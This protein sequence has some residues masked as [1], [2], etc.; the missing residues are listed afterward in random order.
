[1]CMRNK[2]SS[3]VVSTTEPSGD[4]DIQPVSFC[5]ITYHIADLQ[6]LFLSGEERDAASMEAYRETL[7]KLYSGGAY[8]WC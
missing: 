3:V 4:L 2:R 1:M 6:K 5:G 7:S 8:A